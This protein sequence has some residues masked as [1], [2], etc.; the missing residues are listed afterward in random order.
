MFEKIAHALITNG[1]IETFHCYPCNSK[2]QQET[3]ISFKQCIKVLSFDTGKLKDQI[4]IAFRELKAQ[5]GAIALDPMDTF[6]DTVDMLRLEKKG[7]TGTVS[8]PV[9]GYNYQ[10]TQL[11][12]GESV[13]VLLS[14]LVQCIQ[15]GI[16][17]ITSTGQ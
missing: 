8:A 9:A 11:P 17:R 4:K 6:F 14:F 3:T 1:V 5:M 7:N 12:P 15:R 2:K 13:V 10:I 16:L